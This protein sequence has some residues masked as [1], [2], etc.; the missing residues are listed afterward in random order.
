[1]AGDAEAAAAAPAAPCDIY[2]VAHN[3]D[4]FDFPLFCAE[5]ARAADAAGADA[6][7]AAGPLRGGGRVLFGDTCLAA[8][9]LRVPLG[10]RSCSLAATHERLGG[11]RAA[12]R[13][14][15]ARPLLAH[16]ALDDATAVSDIMTHPEIFRAVIAGAHERWAWW[17]PAH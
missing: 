5:V 4:S 1:V 3:G 9:A 8:R 6:T 11:A 15:A 12:A 16:D 10:L 14:H 7:A 13:R 17:L 2:I